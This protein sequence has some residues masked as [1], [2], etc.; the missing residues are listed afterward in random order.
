MIPLWMYPLALACGNTYL[1]KPS[2]RVPLTTM[3]LTSLAQKAGF[4][5]GIF[6]VVHGGRDTVNF[7]CD[8]PAIK[9]ISFVGSNQAGEYIHQ[10]GT[11]NNK[12]VQANLG[13]KNHAIIMPDADK[14]ACL[15]A[16]LAAGFGASGQRCMALS[17]AVFVGDSI[18]WVPDLLEQAKQL[19]A[20]FGMDADVQLGPVI[21]P[22]SRD[23]INS[24]IQSALDQGA[25]VPLDGRDMKVEGYPNGNWVGPTVI[26]DI[27]AAM[28]C[29]T[30]DIFGPGLVCMQA[31]SL[32]EAIEIVNANPYGNGTAIFTRS[33]AAARK[34]QFE[35]DCG[36]VGINVPIPVPLPMFSFTGSRASHRGQ[37]HFYGKDGVRFFTQ[38]KTITSSWKVAN[39]ASA[40]SMSMPILR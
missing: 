12:R 21:T 7:I 28:T 30:E 27:N 15:N 2:E 20:G 9:A 35:I 39:D 1:M 8:E 5:A 11:E 37:L 26:T 32:D 16:L 29:Y 38:V 31:S 10:R 17:V 3:A 23:R 4:P 24:L 36:Q 13:A 40:V 33:G 6:N 22:Q 19:K 34:F 25:N 18:N 14:K